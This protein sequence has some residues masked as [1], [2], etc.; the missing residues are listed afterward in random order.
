ML[1]Q[2]VTA[3]PAMMPWIMVQ[4]AWGHSRA[5]GEGQWNQETWY[6]IGPLTPFNPYLG[7]RGGHFTPYG[8]ITLWLTCAV[9]LL[10]E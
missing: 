10:T 2:E 5:P 8:A 7:K 3:V 9:R 1:G 4:K 6:K